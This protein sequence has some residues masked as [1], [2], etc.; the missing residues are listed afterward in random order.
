M[1]GNFLLSY[2]TLVHQI[3]GVICLHTEILHK[4]SLT[5]PGGI[6]LR[7][8]VLSLFTEEFKLLNL[9][10]NAFLSSVSFSSTLPSNSERIKTLCLQQS[11]ANYA[12]TICDVQHVYLLIVFGSKAYKRERLQNSGTPKGLHVRSIVGTRSVPKFIW[13]FNYL[14]EFC[15]QAYC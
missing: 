7:L 15:V 1:D 2:N 9:C 3:S 10:P 6:T 13:L 8:S 11:K 12:K 4:G 5:F 14:R